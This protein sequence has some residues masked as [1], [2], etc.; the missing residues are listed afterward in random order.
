MSSVLSITRGTDFSAAVQFNNADGTP[1][2]LT[3]YTVTASIAWATTSLS[4]SVS[5]TD[6]V[7][8]EAAISL[9]ETQTAAIPDGRRSKLTI[10][11]T[12]GG[13]QTY[14]DRCD[15]DGV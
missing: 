13:G 12:S 6:A 10:T 5:V 11:Y 8:G 9:T 3:G 2:N 15:V 14:L 1:I 7:A 4:L